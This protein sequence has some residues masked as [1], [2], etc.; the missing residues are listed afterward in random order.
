MNQYAPKFEQEVFTFLLE[1]NAAPNTTVGLLNA[2]DPDRFADFGLVRYE[3]R[4]G[5]DRFEIEKSTGRLFTISAS[6]RQQLDRELI[7]TFFM[8]VDAVDGAGLRTSVQ[9]V[10]K[11]V[12]VNDNAPQFIINS[13]NLLSGGGL[14]SLK[15]ETTKFLIGC[16]EENSANKWIESVRLLAVDRD[17]GPNGAVE[18]E[19]AHVEFG[20]V[21]LFEINNE[22]SFLQLREGQSLDFERLRE[23][24]RHNRTTAAAAAAET[25][26][27]NAGEVD[28]NLVVLAKDLGNPSLSSSVNVKVIVRDVN[29]NKPVFDQLLY[30]T[31]LSESA[32][33]GDVFQVRARDAD[34]EHTGNA[35]VIYAIESGAKDKF[36]IDAS[37]GLIKLVENAELDKDLYGSSYLLKIVA[38]NYNSFATAGSNS[39]SVIEI[40]ASSLE[41]EAE[42]NK[43]DQIFNANRTARTNHCFLRV[44][45][46]DVNNKKPY[47][48]R[49]NE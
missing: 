18:Y 44:R 23:L 47:F 26:S 41:L 37:T 13:N 49:N 22:S 45:I 32:K 6:P 48:L 28:L 3:L 7:D 36:S 31:D 21:G 5:Q 24:A 15:N 30:L 14:Y 43:L 16:I 4:N 25:L 29:D 38:S 1:E 46:V 2:T 33:Y 10:V 12:D 40:E 39:S 35:K 17:A 9:L 34:A 27:L 19:I 20:L 42:N 11:L 8:S